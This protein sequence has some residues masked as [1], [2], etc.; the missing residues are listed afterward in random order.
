MTQDEALEIVK[1]QSEMLASAHNKQRAGFLRAREKLQEK[2]RNNEP[3]DALEKEVA[4]QQMM[5]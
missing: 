5:I 1:R 3:L 2:I 4:V